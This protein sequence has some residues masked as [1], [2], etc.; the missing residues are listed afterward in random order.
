MQAENDIN[1][2]VFL[3]WKHSTNYTPTQFPKPHIKPQRL[4]DGVW[5]SVFLKPS[6]HINCPT[7]QLVQ[8]QECSSAGPT[9]PLGPPSVPASRSLL[10]S[11]AQS[12]THPSFLPR[13]HRC[14]SAQPD[15]DRKSAFIFHL[16]CDSFFLL[17]HPDR[18]EEGTSS[19]KGRVEVG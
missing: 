14:F 8:A 16:L 15:F 4:S 18:T 19:G 1:A 11:S 7:K 12:P 5:F 6:L 3:S 17:S 10:P 2:L 13:S 9:S